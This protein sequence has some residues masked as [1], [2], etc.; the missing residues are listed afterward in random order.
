MQEAMKKGDVVKFKKALTAEKAEA[1]MVI[2]SDPGGGR[3]LVRDISD[4][5]IATCLYI[6]ELELCE[7]A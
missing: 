6:D 4:K 5:K 3:V 1:R 2:L 7:L